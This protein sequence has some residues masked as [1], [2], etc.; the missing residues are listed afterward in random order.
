LE[1][2]HFLIN[3]LI[4]GF[5]ALTSWSKNRLER[6]F[7]YFVIAKK[8]GIEQK[9]D[10]FNYCYLE[11]LYRLV[12]QQKKMK[13]TVSLFAIKEIENSFKQ[14]IYEMNKSSLEISLDDNLH[15]NPLLRSLKNK[16]V[17]LKTEIE[18]F[19]CEFVKVVQETRKPKD[20][21]I[22]NKLDKILE[23]QQADSIKLLK[24]SF[25]E[26]LE[27]PREL[28]TSN[29]Y[30][31]A[32][33]IFE[34]FKENKWEKIDSELK[35]KIL[36]NIGIC[37]LNLNQEEEGGKFL[38][39]A[40]V[41]DPENP[42]ALGLAASGF[43]ILEDEIKAKE[44][45]EK[46]IS[47]NP[48][49]PNAWTGLLEVIKSK[50]EFE[51]I[52]NRMPSSLKR[53]NGIAH[54]LYK[55]YKNHGELKS[56]EQVLRDI[57]QD[58]EREPQILAALGTHL[59]ERIMDP[60]LLK[61]HQL[62]SENQEKVKEGINLL[63]E[64][65]EKIKGKDLEKYR[66]WW[67]VNRGVA[68]KYLSN[69]KGALDDIRQAYEL[70]SNDPFVIR[71]MAIVLFENKEY[72]EAKKHFEKLKKIDAK[73]EII[74]V[75]ICEC[76]MHI[77]EKNDAEEK[78]TILSHSAQD[79]E[80]KKEANSLL[81]KL[82]CQ[83][84]KIKE[85]YNLANKE[86]EKDDTDIT[87]YLDLFFVMFEEK[88]IDEA[89]QI[90]NKAFL[91]VNNDTE[92]IIVFEVA[93]KLFQV[94]E[95]EKAAKL[96]SQITDN[97]LFTPVN[98]KLLHS[99]VRSGN[100]GKTL[101]LAQ[102][103]INSQGFIPP[104]VEIAS[105]VYEST[106][107]LLAAIKICE[108][109]ME[110]NPFNYPIIARL[111]NLYYR[112]GDKD[113]LSI[114]LSLIKD[115]SDFPILLQFK[116]AYLNSWIGKVDLALEISYNARR[117][118][119]SNGQTHLN[120][121]QLNLQLNPDW[122]K[123]L[124]MEVVAA[125]STVSI[126]NE[127]NHNLTFTILKEK[128]IFADR[129]EINVDELLSIALL[130]KKVNEKVILDKGIGHPKEYKIVSIVHKYAFA[131]KESFE[132][133]SEKFITTKGITMFDLNK[134]AEDKD[135]YFKPINDLLDERHEFDE[136]MH[137]FYKSG[138]FPIG[139]IASLKNQ[140][141]I[142]TWGW[143]I[144]ND[145]GFITLA[146]TPNEY[147]ISVEQLSKNKK[148]LL[149]I[150][151]ILTLSELNL[152]EN[153]K[154]AKVELATANST[155]EILR[156]EII[157]CEGHEKGF[158]SL[159]KVNGQYFK[160]EVTKEM[161]DKNI[162]FLKNVLSWIEKNS[163]IL[164]CEPI[165]SINEKDREHFYKVYGKSFYET[166]LIA[167]DKNFIVLSDD[168]VYRTYIRNENGVCGLSTASFLFYLQDTDKLDFEKF[169]KA[170]VRLY[171]LGYNGLYI[172]SEILWLAFEEAKF[173]LNR[174][175]KNILPMLRGDL[176][177][178]GRIIAK[179]VVDFLYKLYTH[180]PVY[181]TQDF[182]C[183]EVIKNSITNRNVIFIGMLLQFLKKRFLLL[184]REYERV[185]LN[186]NSLI[187]KL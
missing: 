23:L 55:Q 156:D 99:Y 47:K 173:T 67:F 101:E 165:L 46:A 91:L 119:Y 139:S 140:N 83:N 15:T 17:D 146:A 132:L 9:R 36:A 84:G 160:H 18:E 86:I 163:K 147:K 100:L 186:I 61:T 45:A 40:V 90:L 161:I 117:K 6:D 136:Q 179:T 174:P 26:D 65:I 120:F 77:D 5:I 25:I 106:G 109:C 34:K 185:M 71:H 35:F 50:E 123:L 168:G 125:D 44:Y 4:K 7:K 107:D 27:F 164:P 19:K 183:I 131:S 31:Q 167:L 88:N 141:P 126:C 48:N 180:I 8:I 187:Q 95:F 111:A 182:F 58:N 72:K 57:L 133:L 94:N 104:V 43:A 122:N 80:V 158:F 29:N 143:I 149:D 89:K 148:I 169:N 10:D 32:L 33:S 39:E 153:I 85:A 38:T 62:S 93:E 170:I 166:S 112:I 96:Y 81:I 152:L 87:S 144:S 116:L 108:N 56:A 51:S 159:G 22:T 73:D 76:L 181:E 2:I 145:L 20:I 3:P 49:N 121:T 171:S 118:D 42:K 60:F 172:N 69:N 59:L 151:S 178:D 37:K 75:A 155:V 92:N 102:K 110:N 21:E 54:A 128:E 113:K 24:T 129:G 175:F 157:Q 115:Y 138:S 30:Q 53:N 66:W 124:R 68:K 70:N 127:S 135:E 12:K 41:Y 78:L 16:S 52:L 114:T 74:D 134:N 63:T 14:E 64:A 97:S 184:P 11:T 130:G 142:E 103:I 137:N 105:Y 150:T 98:Q 154:E 13:E 1:P 82:H 176:V 162:T 28:M 177:A 79:R